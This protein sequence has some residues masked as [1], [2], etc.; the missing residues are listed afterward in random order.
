MVPSLG[1]YNGSLTGKQVLHILITPAIVAR[2]YR[3]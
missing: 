2:V 3:H 1:F